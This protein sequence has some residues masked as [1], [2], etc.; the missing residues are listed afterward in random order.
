MFTNPVSFNGNYHDKKMV[1]ELVTNPFSG[2]QIRL[3][4]FLL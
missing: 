3:Q 2:C 1:M 4:V